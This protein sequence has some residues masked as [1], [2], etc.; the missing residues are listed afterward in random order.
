MVY[1]GIQPL[2]HSRSAD[3]QQNSQTHLPPGSPLT[4]TSLNER[5]TADKEELGWWPDLE[6]A[7]ETSEER[8]K[9]GQG[10]RLAELKTTVFDTYAICAALLASFACATTFISEKEMLVEAAWRRYAVQLQQFLVRVCIIGGIHAML[11]F[12]FCALYA[13]S[14]LARETYG[15]EVY[16][17]FSRDT[18]KVRQLGFLSMYCTAILYSVQIAISTVYSL[19]VVLALTTGSIMLLVICR[20]VWD[21][22]SIIRSAACVFMSE[23]QVKKLVD[24]EEGQR[25]T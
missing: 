15:L 8:F 25:A 18:G 14:A 11:V 23:E 10:F 16:E 20:V 5:V 12:M 7:S 22:Q 9:L 1:S 13:K 3:H 19:P 21:A 6:V 4:S 24:A 17:R 2:I